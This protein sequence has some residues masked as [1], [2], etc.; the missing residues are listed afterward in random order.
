[1][2]TTYS[3]FKL[4]QPWLKQPHW[5][6][7]TW[8]TVDW[9]IK[10]GIWLSEYLVSKHQLQLIKTLLI[11]FS[12]LISRGSNNHTEDFKT[13]V[14][15]QNATKLCFQTP[16]SVAAVLQQEVVFRNTLFLQCRGGRRGR[17]PTHFCTNFFKKSPK[18]AQQILGP[19]PRTPCATSFFKSWIRPCHSSPPPSQDAT[20]KT[21]NRVKG[22]NI[23]INLKDTSAKHTTK[24]T[25]MS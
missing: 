7:K 6:F 8:S 5:G 14:V 21:I 20:E 4:D 18:L 19:R 1:M 11:V 17:T 3:F 9:K 22:L 25:S 13:L 2:K 12:N 24:M 15:F 10:I 23:R 16:K